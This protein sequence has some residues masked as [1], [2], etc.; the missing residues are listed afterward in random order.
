MSEEVKAFVRPDS[1]VPGPA[2]DQ[3]PHPKIDPHDS[4]EAWFQPMG[5]SLRLIS[6]SQAVLQAAEISFAGFG[7][8]RPAKEPDFTFRFF[9]HDR[10][11]G[12][13]S[14]PIFRLEG[15]LLRQTSGRDSTL[16]ACL[17]TGL[18][19][20]QFS[21][22]VLTH[23]AFFRWHFLE[24]ALFM[25]LEFKGLMGVHGAALVKDGQAVLL[26]ARSGGGKTTLAY[27]G[28]RHRL[29]ALAE[30]VV[31]LDRRQNLWWGTPWS[32]HLLPDARHL[33]PELARYSPV[34]QINGE[35][36]LE[37]NLEEI[38]R[39][40][41]TFSARPGPVVLVERL[42]GGKSRLEPISAAA[43]REAWPAGQTGLEMQLPHHT[44]CVEQLLRQDTYRL[45]FGDDIEASV[46]LL[47]SLFEPN[48]TFDTMAT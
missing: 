20:G 8:A 23:Q 24:M 1:N 40:S 9:E 39:G 10:D 31:W 5:Y 34:L 3:N 27:A 16:L 4:V 47:E 30:D 15:K 21:G 6:N 45:Y 29:M 14:Q 38:R 7:T 46:T 13:L 28:A 48:V 22:T 18:A 44:G 32:F 36:K 35:T 19:Y 17:D 12:Q 37:I 25:M 2:D 33:F 41:T 42:A 11:D 26:R 43:A